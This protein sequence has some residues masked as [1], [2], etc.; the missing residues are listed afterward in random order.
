MTTKRR[1]NDKRKKRSLPL[2]VEKYLTGKND[3]DVVGSFIG[4]LMKRYK[5]EHDPEKQLMIIQHIILI[6]LQ[7]YTQKNSE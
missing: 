2:L 5:D 6:A 7:H 3:E 4:D 1:F